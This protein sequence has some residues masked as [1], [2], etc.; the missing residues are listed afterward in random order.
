LNGA[1]LQTSHSWDNY[2]Q[3][4]SGYNITAPVANASAVLDTAQY[5][6]TPLVNDILQQCGLQKK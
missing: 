6:Y 3:T 2:K 5:I 4:W 1:K